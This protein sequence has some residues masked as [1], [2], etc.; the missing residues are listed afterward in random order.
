ME[1]SKRK[2]TWKIA[3]FYQFTELADFDKLAD[4]IVNHGLELGI[5]GTFIIS[6]EGINST[7]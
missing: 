5:R 2:D 6:K 3:A 7:C 4:E 1:D